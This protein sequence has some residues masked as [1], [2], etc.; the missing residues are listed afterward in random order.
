LRKVLGS[1][2]SRGLHTRIVVEE[3]VEE[4]LLVEVVVEQLLLLEF[5]RTF[6][7]LDHGIEQSSDWCQRLAPGAGL[8]PGV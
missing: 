7:G 5:L 1:Y 3:E 8:L 2:I 6:C 4:L